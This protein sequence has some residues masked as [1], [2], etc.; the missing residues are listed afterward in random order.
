MRTDRAAVKAMA[1]LLAAAVLSACQTASY[2]ATSQLVGTSWRAADAGT[3]PKG[4]N[5]SE[6]DF[7][8][9][10]A[11]SGMGQVR[12]DSK[13]IA[14]F[15]VVND[16]LLIRYNYLRGRTRSFDLVMTQQTLTL[17]ALSPDGKALGIQH[18]NRQ[19]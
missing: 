15:Q 9:K 7:G 5:F 14:Y 10:L 13:K 16:A 1:M 6:L 19:N 2:E 3:N 11:P 17:K 18:F 8:D 12:I 4:D